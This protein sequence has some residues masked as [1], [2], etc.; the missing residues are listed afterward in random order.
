MLLTGMTM[1]LCGVTPPRSTGTSAAGPA[2]SSPP[3][4][5]PPVVPPIPA[6]PSTVPTPTKSVYLPTTTPTAAP[7][8]MPAAASPPVQQPGPGPMATPAV[9]QVPV[10][11]QIPVVSEIPAATQLPVQPA[12]VTTVVAKVQ[13]NTLVTPRYPEKVP[14]G[15]FSGNLVCNGMTFFPH[16][17]TAVFQTGD[18]GRL[19]MYLDSPVGSCQY[20]VWAVCDTTDEAIGCASG[21]QAWSCRYAKFDRWGESLGAFRG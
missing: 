6:T 7:T 20:K 8:A 5:T 16:P 3:S 1:R 17:S 14:Q 9:S 18:D 15:T 4:Q 10:V 19:V 12:T 2:A 11:S 21:W 13:P